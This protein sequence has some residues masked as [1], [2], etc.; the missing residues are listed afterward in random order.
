MS[1]PGL[2]LIR[3]EQLRSGFGPGCASG[4]GHPI[5]Y[6]EWP[7]TRGGSAAGERRQEPFTTRRRSAQRL[8]QGGDEIAL[9]ALLLLGRLAHPTSTAHPRVVYRSTCEPRTNSTATP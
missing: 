7:S 2:I 8:W 6:E 9:M 1:A 4:R 5:S 3:G